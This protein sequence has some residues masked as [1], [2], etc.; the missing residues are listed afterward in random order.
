MQ[1]RAIT[2]MLSSLS[3]EK[4]E[5]YEKKLK[6]VKNAWTKRISFPES[7]L[8]VSRLIEMLPQ[9]REILVSLCGLREKDSR[10]NDV[11]DA[12]RSDDNVFCNVLVRTIEGAKEVA[13]LLTKLEPE[14]ATRFAVLINDD[15]LNT[16]YFPASTSNVVVDS[17]ALA[18]LYVKDYS[19]GETSKAFQTAN[20]YGYEV[21]KILKARFLGIDISLSPWMEESVGEIIEMR[22]GKIFSLGNTWAV[23]EVN[24]EIFAEAWKSRITPI[25]FSET[26][27]PVAED[28][29]LRERV[30][31]G[32]LTLSNLF[33]LTFSCA[34]GIDMVGVR[35]DRE[36][37]ENLIK[38]SIA[39]QFVKRRPYA[40]RIIPVRGEESIKTE[41]FGI[42]PSIKVV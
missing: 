31:E 2:L 29:V 13:K 19:K 10:L 30:L 1:I 39:I 15:F 17:F 22:S 3:K 24:R 6:E 14:E 34:S 38:D 32:S 8:S 41:M 26:M 33:Q 28:N 7:D 12:L 21:S 42:I 37:F 11:V 4:V 23:G 5:H 9:D 36:L 40:I 25:G 16:P 18:L 35:E 20:Q 27:L